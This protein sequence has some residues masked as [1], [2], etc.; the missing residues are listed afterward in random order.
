MPQDLRRGL[1]VSLSS[2]HRVQFPIPPVQREALPPTFTCPRVPGKRPGMQS[3]LSEECLHFAMEKGS[4][5]TE[6]PE[7][8]PFKGESQAHRGMN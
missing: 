2:L 3:V 5:S 1:E 7:L 4:L 6:K 8:G